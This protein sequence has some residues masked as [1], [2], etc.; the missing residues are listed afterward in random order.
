MVAEDARWGMDVILSGQGSDIS[1]YLPLLLGHHWV[2]IAYEGARVLRSP[3]P[4][5]GVPALAE[6][7]RSRF[8]A[9]T[10]QGRHAA[11][12][13]DDT[14]KSYDQ[15]LGE[16]E[17]VLGEHS[18]QLTGRTPRWLRWAAT[19]LG[20]YEIDGRVAGASVSAGYRLGVEVADGGRLAG[21]DVRAV[22]EEWGGTL[23]V[24]GAA[25]LDASA[26]VATME[27]LRMLRIGYRDR[28]ASQYFRGRFDPDFTLGLKATLLLIEGD[29]NA[30][31]RLLPLTGT[32]HEQAVFRAQTITVYHALTAL[33]RVVQRYADSDVNGLRAVRAA[34]QDPPANRLLSKQGRLVRNH[35]MHYSIT[36]PQVCLDPSQP[37][38]GLVEAIF[39]GNTWQDFR[40]DV[41]TTT[42]SMADH[43]HSWRPG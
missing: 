21:Q 3:D 11:K 18:L 36:D 24:L 5:L 17:A 16:L 35:C 37:M 32:G 20:L 27:P 6:L 26:P 42:A 8:S 9:I 28:L 15:V 34:L 38:Y 30:S 12:L 39:P 41:L 43:L 25:A 23:A 7:L 13:L 14:K 2:R 19:D 29:L 22:S 33:R 1:G 10:A 40:A 31:L 4:L